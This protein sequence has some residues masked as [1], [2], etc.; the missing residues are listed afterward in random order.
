MEIDLKDVTAVLLIDGWHKVVERSL[1]FERHSFTAADGK[2][3]AGFRHANQAE[4][5]DFI[6]E[7]PAGHG[8][9]IGPA[10]SIL[11]MRVRG[12]G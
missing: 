9:V 3:A 5:M 1:V 2:P 12:P 4:A 11:A 7:E 8:S 6:F 10:S